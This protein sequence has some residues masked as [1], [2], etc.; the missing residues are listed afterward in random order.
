LLHK[1]GI[2]NNDEEELIQDWVIP[3]NQATEFIEFIFDKID[4]Q[5]QPWV[6]L[7]IVPK[8][9]ATLYPLTP[10]QPYMNIGCYCFAKRPRQDQNHY[11]TKILDEMCFKMSGIKMLYSST[12]LTEDRFNKIYNG[13]QYQA[14]KEKYDPQSRSLTLYEKAAKRL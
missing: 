8:R 10:S 14:L 7:P 13:V 2:R 5:G 12:F 3:W 4:I 9:Q 6:A 11:Y 1:V